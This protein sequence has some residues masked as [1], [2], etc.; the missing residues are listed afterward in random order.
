MSK[1]DYKQFACG[2][3]VHVYNRGNNREDIFHDEEDYR[4]FLFRLGL[5]LGFEIKEL[6]DHS[7]TSVPHSRIRITS[8]KKGSFK[9][10]AFCLM[11]NHFHFL[12]EQCS[13]TPISKLISKICT[14]YA[15]YFNLKY[16]RVG[17]LFQDKFK[18][19]LMETQPQLMWTSAYIHTNPVKDG[20]AKHSSQYP[21][22][23]Y[24]DYNSDRNLPIICKD[25]IE[26]IFKNN[27]EEETA[28][29][30]KTVFDTLNFQN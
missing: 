5:G 20:F 28:K 29:M 24:Q 13:D 8:S 15:K 10:H 27:F 17:H 12:I 9:L 19:T 3:I 14:S 25:M 7:L 23:S 26:S 2:S 30:S 22:S 6:S 18:S 4:A 21:W 11:R 16:K 1:R